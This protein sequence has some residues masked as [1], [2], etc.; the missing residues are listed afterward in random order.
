MEPEC[1]VG[2]MVY[3]KSVNFSDIEVGDVISFRLNDGTMV[4]HRVDAINDD[5]TLRTKGDANDVADASPV[6]ESQ[7]FGEVK[8]KLPYLGYLSSFIK[9]ASGI[10][11]LIA[12][13]VIII[14]LSVIPGFFKKEDAEENK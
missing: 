7:V 12:L 9:S 5:G 2:S 3:V 8:G 10:A 14:V 13:A 1:P 11:T 4:T 6:S